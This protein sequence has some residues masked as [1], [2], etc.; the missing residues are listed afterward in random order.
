MSLNEM[1]RNYF[2]RLHL[3]SINYVPGTVFFNFLK[4]FLHLITIAHLLVS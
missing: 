3:L 2:N 1:E 4:K